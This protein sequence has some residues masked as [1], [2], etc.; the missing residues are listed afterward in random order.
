MDHALGFSII[1][2]HF[3]AMFVPHPSMCVLP[4][5]Y[6]TNTCVPVRQCPSSV[7]QNNGA[8][9]IKFFLLLV[10]L[11]VVVVGRTRHH[12]H[13]RSMFFNTTADTSPVACI[14]YNNSPRYALSIELNRPE[15]YSCHE[16]VFLS[17]GLCSSLVLF[18]C[19]VH[20]KCFRAFATASYADFEFF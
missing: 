12:H 10:V 1:A 13:K 16:F 11:F 8:T 2:H 15:S 17:L 3:F 7:R 20:H 14:K 4:T 18:G 19:P 6:H 5:S 9:G